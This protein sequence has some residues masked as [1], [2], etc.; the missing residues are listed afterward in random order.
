[1][2]LDPQ[3]KLEVSAKTSR[4]LHVRPT[5]LQLRAAAIRGLAAGPGPNGMEKWKVD[6]ILMEF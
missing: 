1:M 4:V 3:E 6:G 2:A 5:G